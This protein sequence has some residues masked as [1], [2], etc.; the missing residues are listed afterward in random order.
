MYSTRM[1]VGTILQ[2]FSK[3]PFLLR[4]RIIPNEATAGAPGTIRP[5]ASWFLGPDSCFSLCSC[6]YPMAHRNEGHWVLGNHVFPY[7]PRSL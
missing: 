1:E 7:T 6:F 5:A 2:Y 4:N 3:N